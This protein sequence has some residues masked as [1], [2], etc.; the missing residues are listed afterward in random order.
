MDLVSTEDILKKINLSPDE[1]RLEMAVY[2]YQQ[3]RLSMGQ[4]RHL[5]SV[6][7]H[8]FQKELKKRGVHIHYDTSDLEED[9]RN[10]GFERE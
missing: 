3:E 10:L 5:A 2:L 8:T 7:Q 1:L 6:D 4:A 9:L